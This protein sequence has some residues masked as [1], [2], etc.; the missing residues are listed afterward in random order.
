MPTSFSHRPARHWLQIDISVP[1]EL[2]EYVSH[3]LTDITGNGVQILSKDNKEVIIAYLEKNN[4]YQTV[5]QELDLFL[6][7]LSTKLTS[8]LDLSLN[9][10]VEENWAENW[11]ENYKPSRITD[12]ITVKPTWETYTP[13]E[14][15]IVIDIDPGMAFGT[16]LH[17]STRLA[18]TFIDELFASAATRPSTV[19]DVGTGTGILAIATAKLGALKVM[20][21]DNDIDAVVAAR[22]NIQQNHEA[23]HVSCAETDLADIAD[24]YDLVIANITAD[25]LTL[26]CSE[27]V[28]RMARGGHL[29]LAGI[30]QGEQADNVVRCFQAASLHLINKKTEGKWISLLFSNTPLP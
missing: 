14:K 25:I 5:R 18:L 19:L 12:T 27:L 28:K 16:G 8:P 30:L 24:S 11:K 21:I 9:T 29:I 1:A 13:G 26:L 7:D 4:E 23:R 15:E 20:A 2:M 17:S 10:I 22:D 3:K 6:N